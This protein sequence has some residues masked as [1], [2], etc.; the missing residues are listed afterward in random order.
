[1]ALNDNNRLTV[2]DYMH[3]AR[4]RYGAIGANSVGVLVGLA[5]LA[6]IIVLSAPAGTETGRAGRQTP[7]TTMAPSNPPAPATK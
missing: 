6:L 1:M 2:H 4:S 7:G 3:G 5:V